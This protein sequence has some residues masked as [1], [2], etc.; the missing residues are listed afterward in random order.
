MKGTK[1]KKERKKERKLGDRINLFNPLPVDCR[2]FWHGLCPTSFFILHLSLGLQI[3]VISLS[4]RTIKTTLSLLKSNCT[5]SLPLFLAFQLTQLL[6]QGAVSLNST[7]LL[8]LLFLAVSN[9]ERR[10]S[11]SQPQTKPN[12]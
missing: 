8:W 5:V 7:Q 4:V 2:H 9:Q 10:I 11:H 12:K 6:L 3:L 1:E